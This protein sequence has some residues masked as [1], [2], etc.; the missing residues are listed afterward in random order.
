VSLLVLLEER[1]HP[2][3]KEVLPSRY[4]NIKNQFSNPNPI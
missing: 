3:S 2:G 4:A 1:E